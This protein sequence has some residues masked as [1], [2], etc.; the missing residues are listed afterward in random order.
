MMKRVS[1]VCLAWL[2]LLAL[3]LLLL[4]IA[5]LAV[6]ADEGQEAFDAVETTDKQYTGYE[7]GNSDLDI[8]LIGRY[9]AGAMSGDGGSAEIVVYNPANGDAYVINGLKGTL[10]RVALDGLESSDTVQDID[11]Q[12][13]DVKALVEGQD[14]SFTYGDMTSVTVSPD[15]TKVAVS[16][17]DA[18]YDKA[19]RAVL[20]TCGAD[21]SLE[22][23]AMAE[24]GVQPDMITFNGDGTILLTADEGE[25]RD[26]YGEGAVD[27]KGSV[28]IITVDG[29]TAQTVGFDSFDGTRQDLVDTGVILKKDTAPSVDLEPE[30]IAV[31]GDNA[32]VTL[33]EANAI[34]VLDIDNGE[35]IGIY[36]IGFE[37]YSVTPVDI[38][39]KDEKYDSKTYDGLMG[40]RMP[41]A[42]AVYNVNGTDYLVTANEGDSREWG[43]YLN[44]DEID[45]GEEGAVSPAGNITA[46][47]SSLTG[48]VVF[49]NA[50]DYDGLEADTDYLF[51]GRTFTILRAT[52]TGLETVYTSSDDFEQLTAEYIP[53]NFNCSNDDKTVD[54]RSGK[55]GPEP[56]TVTLGTIDGRTYAFVTLERPSGVMIY[57][58][59]D[60]ANTV[61]VNYINSRDFSE[62]VK[63]DVSPE[64]LKFIPAEESPTDKPLLLAACEVSGTMAVYEMTPV[65]ENEPTELPFSDVDSDE[66]FYD[67]VKYVYDNGLMN[68]VDGGMFDPDGTTTRAQIVTILYR[69]AG[70]PDISDENL[71]YPYEDVDADSWYG[72]AVYWARTAGIAGGYDNG[73]FGPDDAI[74]RE[75]MAAMLYRYAEYKDYDVS[76][77]ASLDQFSDGDDASSWAESSV[78]W[79]VAEGLISGGDGNV[80]QPQGSAIRA[81]AATILMRFCENIA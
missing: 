19:G 43:D 15:G 27:P 36:S 75:Q 11:G 21:G 80:L 77:S 17:Q 8:T 64:G 23:S 67:A 12:E 70:S 29:M 32:Y 22:Y 69:L 42:I 73:S 28:T 76:G 47:D 62:D 1:A 40:I 41:D 24:T 7:N 63:D 26:G 71:G 46:E 50:Q 37:D 65:Q 45:F 25:P 61:Y 38:D 31:S 5:A 30:Y 53:E 44:E 48:K 58:I 72:D 56:E 52:D 74:T 55:K 18:G 4:P 39:K 51:G 79:A 57:D 78:S 59:T 33:Q 2:I 54:D 6:E 20:F 16:L 60:P 35:F 9:N 68:G 49:F 3:G 81:Q 14:D 34:A 66:W 13:I 10:D